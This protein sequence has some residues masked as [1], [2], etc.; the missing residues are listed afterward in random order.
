MSYYKKR[1]HCGEDDVDKNGRKKHKK[2]DFGKKIQTQT[3]V[4]Q[5]W[6]NCPQCEAAG[7]PCATRHLQGQLHLS[8]P[9]GFQNKGKHI[10]HC[11]LPAMQAVTEFHQYMMCVYRVDPGKVKS[12]KIRNCA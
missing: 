7:R 5:M 12:G 8:A 10:T 6:S 9:H 4:P 1:Q 11:A 3:R 2:R